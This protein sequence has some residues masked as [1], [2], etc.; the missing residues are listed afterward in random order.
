MLRN[1]SLLKVTDVSNMITRSV[2][3][4]IKKPLWS[5]LSLTFSMATAKAAKMI[6]V[7]DLTS[8]LTIVVGR[9]IMIK[10]FR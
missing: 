2:R 5:T 3:D 4:R 6:C 8:W 9:K 10:Q 7:A 1:F